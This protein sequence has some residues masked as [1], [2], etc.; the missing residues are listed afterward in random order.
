MFEN[1]QVLSIYYINNKKGRNVNTK[2][3][4]DMKTFRQFRSSVWAGHVTNIIIISIWQT[5]VVEKLVTT[6]IIKEN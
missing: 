1:E 3:V 6:E 5:G 4:L 2:V